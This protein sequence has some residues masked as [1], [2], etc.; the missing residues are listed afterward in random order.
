MVAV[1]AASCSSDVML[2]DFAA[3]EQ[4]NDQNI[5]EQINSFITK[6]IDPVYEFDFF[7]SA[8]AYAQF[9]NELYTRD[10][11]N[12]P[13][14]FYKVPKIEQGKLT[15]DFAKVEGQFIG[16]KPNGRW[17]YR[18]ADGELK[19]NFVHF[20]G[21]RPQKCELDARFNTEYGFYSIEPSRYFE[22]QIPKIMDEKILIDGQKAGQGWIYTNFLDDDREWG[23]SSEI[24]IGREF[25][26][27]GLY[28][29]YAKQ[30]RLIS[31]NFGKI[32]SIYN[33]N[34]LFGQDY[35]DG[36]DY[37]GQEYEQLIGVEAYRDNG[38]YAYYR[39]SLGD[40]RDE[41]ELVW[42]SMGAG[43][44]ENLAELLEE[45]INLAKGEEFDTISLKNRI[46]DFNANDSVFMEY[47]LANKSVIMGSIKLVLEEPNALFRNSH[48]RLVFSYEL[49]ES[50][51][52]TIIE[53][54]IEDLLLDIRNAIVSLHDQAVRY[55]NLQVE[56]IRNY[57]EGIKADIERYNSAVAGRINDIANWISQ[58]LDLSSQWLKGLSEYNE[59]FIMNLLGYIGEYIQE[60]NEYFTPK[61]PQPID[62][63]PILI[64]D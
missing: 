20:D 9:A 57:L 43:S 46:D 24:E 41:G 25:G 27:L 28:Y 44:L 34:K 33:K 14:A 6:R 29:D 62:P 58:N 48:I 1:L 31:P 7:E 56:A 49:G 26:N 40:L 51:E 37:Y 47:W 4:Q 11:S 60:I 39:I 59:E 54:P 63:E 55:H 17:A 12:L 38:G 5:S 42:L 52:E 30:A 35:Y 8:A 18:P 61:M 64:N 15:L 22:I 10:N 3:V 32:F 16:E 19:F 13:L 45:N 50:M 36:C 2:D 53:A 23:K 21:P